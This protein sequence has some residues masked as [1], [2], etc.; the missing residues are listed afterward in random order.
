VRRGL[1]G[2]L[3]LVVV[4]FVLGAAPGRAMAH[5][6]YERSDPSPNA[7]LARAP[8]EVRV[9]FT[10]DAELRFSE[11]RVYDGARHR[12]DRDNLAALPGSARAL[13]VGLGDLSP[14][15][16]SVAWKTVSAV[17]GHVA[18]GAFPFTVGLDQTPAPVALP[19]T[20]AGGAPPSPWAIVSRWLSLLAAVVLVGPFVF[21]PRVLGGALRLV[22]PEDAAAA[23]AAWEAGRR[24][25]LGVAA[26]AAG[27]GLGAAVLALVV[28][29]AAAADVE[30][31]QALGAPLG[32][33][34]AT[35]YAAIWAGRVA[36]V[37]ALGALA[38]RLRR[39]AVAVD[40]RGWLLGLGLGAGLLAAQSATSHAAATAPGTILALGADWA[41]LAA[42]AIWLGGLVQIVVALPAALGALP[43]PLRAA[44]LAALLPRFS[45]WA[46]ASV[47]ALA[48]TGLYQAWAEIGD[49]E[50]LL[51]TTYGQALLV[52]LGLVLFLL[53]LGAF[54]LRVVTPRVGLAARAAPRAP[55][56][57]PAL[58][59]TARALRRA[60]AAEVGLG[61][62]VLAVVGVLTSLEPARDVVRAEGL[63]RTLRAED[64]QVQL[65][66]APGV[67]GLNTVDAA[68]LAAGQPL[69]DVQRIT[70][71]FTHH[72]MDMGTFE[73]R[74]SPS[75][76]GHY[77]LSTS[78]FSMAGDWGIEAVVRR[79]GRDDVS[80]SLD[81]PIAEAGAFH[82]P[83]GTAAALP[84]AVAVLALGLPFLAPGGR[85]APLAGRRKRP[86]A[87]RGR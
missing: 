26:G 16:Y 1:R 67:A 28:Q 18:R 40:H 54:N 33:L 20:E 74:L 31:W 71:R 65:R 52:K 84:L 81:L 83:S 70:L 2:A 48:V 75:G 63:A 39:P 53:A 32:A 37:V 72:E 44:T 3:G 46:I 15:T 85:P 47:A 14:G 7:I 55:D 24:R 61:V 49:W 45:T 21:L 82:N 8:S 30:P 78:A 13:V 58:A 34:F 50:A 23:A 59:A 29:A 35:R 79:A 25:G 80:G 57:A 66:V 76:D 68:V 9:W 17:D 27:L 10:E 60:V 77:R 12:V 69:P 36:C 73:Q 42:A 6:T 38:L 43:A 86:R 4:A 56:A 11:L 19:G 22:A 5:A 64:V 51:G 62:A 41:H 87:L